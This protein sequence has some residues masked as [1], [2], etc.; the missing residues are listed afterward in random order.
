MNVT[1]GKG[2][3]GATPYNVGVNGEDTKFGSYLQASA[4]RGGHSYGGGGD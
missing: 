2:G 3:T 4:G 1:V